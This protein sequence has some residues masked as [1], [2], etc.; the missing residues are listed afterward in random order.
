MISPPASVLQELDASLEV[1][2]ALRHQQKPSLWGH[3]SLR[4][5]PNEIDAFED[6]LN[7]AFTAAHG[8]I[9]TSSVRKAT[10][11]LGVA[12]GASPTESQ[13]ALIISRLGTL[14]SL[15]KSL[16]KSDAVIRTAFKTSFERGLINTANDIQ[17]VLYQAKKVTSPKVT[18]AF[19]LTN[20]EAIKALDARGVQMV[21]QITEG[22][23]TLM[24]DAIRSAFTET[25]PGS[26]DEI[27]A[28]IYNG[29]SDPEKYV[30]SQK[31][32]KSIVDTELNS[33]E[34]EA[35]LRE[36]KAS[37]LTRKKWNAVDALACP[38]CLGN[39]AM[40]AV[41]MD[42][43]FNSVFGPTLHPPGHPSVCHCHLSLDMDEINS[44]AYGD[45]GP[46]Y[47]TGGDDTVELRHLPGKH[48]QK[49]HGS[50]WSPRGVLYDLEDAND[51]SAWE[52]H[53]LHG[54]QQWNGKVAGEYIKGSG[55]RYEPGTS[56]QVALV[57][58][59]LDTFPPALVER[60]AIPAVFFK[61]RIEAL[62]DVGDAW[63]LST[64][65]GI[66]IKKSLPPEMAMFVLHHEVGHAIAESV[67]G[68]DLRQLESNYKSFFPKGKA[69]ATPSTALSKAD[70][71]EKWS[72][73]PEN[74][75]PISSYAMANR[76]EYAA[77]T[78]GT[79][80][81]LRRLGNIDP[82]RS[83]PVAK[84]VFERVIQ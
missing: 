83:D 22:T 79:A 1:F 10:A 41:P 35:R 28:A 6:A 7:E 54:S 19:D 58:N 32:V 43:M 33:I 78:L 3:A 11:S 40:G 68:T 37:G 51:A 57:K 21:K 5:A 23:R 80:A 38:I 56:E 39:Q 76:F 8:T 55:G 12:L 63:G 16:G 62:E 9:T 65:G 66:V 42:A 17:S 36:M 30:F 14:V 18:M 81:Y 20:P 46:P 61:D 25:G 75:R 82:L 13:V 69:P 74:K 84:E 15:L 44:L 4:A 77:E 67:K 60:A 31:R 53:N 2:L 52:R 49:M 70:A 27:A 24:R 45:D 29:L 48:D 71:A 73:L 64:A 34:S 72:R 47:W 59:V 50:K 26:P